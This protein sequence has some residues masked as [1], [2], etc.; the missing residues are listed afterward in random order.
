MWST[1]LEVS[2]LWWVSF[3]WPWIVQSLSPHTHIFHCILLLTSSLWDSC[4]VYK[5]DKTWWVHYNWSACFVDTTVWLP[6]T[7][8]LP[9]FPSW[10]LVTLC[11]LLPL[12]KSLH[13]ATGKSC[14]KQTWHERKL[15]IF[16]WIFLFCQQNCFFKSNSHSSINQLLVDRSVI[17]YQRIQWKN[18]ES[19]W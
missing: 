2:I 14:H 3:M 16:W 6:F 7:K 17:S 11:S 19:V 18:E 8:H 1:L 15:H 5:L 10:H 13:T 4:Q 9:S 12:E